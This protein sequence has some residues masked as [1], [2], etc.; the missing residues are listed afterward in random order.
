MAEGPTLGFGVDIGGSGIKGAT[1]DL[2]AGALTMERIRI[3]T[4][5]PA[6]PEAVCRVVDQL[7][8]QAGW[9]GEIGLTLPA[10]VERGVAW[11][12]ANIDK[13][14][15]GTDVVAAVKEAT[16]RPATVLND[17]DA[18]GLAEV[19][20]GAAKGVRG[21][22]LVLT[23]GT[24][25]GSALFVDGVLLPNTELGHLEL[26]GE[27]AE[28]RASA[29]AREREDLSYK[30]WAPRVEKYLRHVDFLLR[31]D[32]VVLGGGVSKKAE[33]WLP[34]L[35]VRPEL[36]PAALRNGAGIVG[37]ALVAHEDVVIGE[38]PGR[39]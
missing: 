35:D 10:V 36:R 32:L 21:V 2:D 1:V 15:I 30:R 33:K 12:A 37:A 24:G 20:F 38:K 9:D 23:L 29:S 22:V 3:P 8:D 6:T 5:Q 34:L 31:P 16:G 28:K 26:D 19:R 39:V 7:V 25:I 13:S 27:D 4:P 14:W 11:S 18:A 17:A